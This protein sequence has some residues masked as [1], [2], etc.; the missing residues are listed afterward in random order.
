[1]ELTDMCPTLLGLLGLPL[2]PGI[3]GID[4]SEALRTGD[5][6][7]REDV[8][9]DMFN[10][11]PMTH[12]RASGPYGAVRT[13]RTA[14]WKLNVYPTFGPEYGQLFDLKNDP[15]ETVNLYGDPAH[16][17]TRENMLWRLM[18]R[19]H[20]NTDPLPRRLTQW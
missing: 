8:Y 19:M 6:I 4:W 7:A 3:Q 14:D 9:V 11:D 18:E 2:H 13:L 17:N 10:M 1:V 5:E 16:R 20:N 15:R 12:Y